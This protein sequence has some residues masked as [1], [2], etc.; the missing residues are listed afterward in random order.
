[1]RH[2]N[3]TLCGALGLV[4]HRNKTFYGALG[5]VRHINEP[6]CGA[7]SSMRHINFF[8]HPSTPPVDRLFSVQKITK[9]YENFKKNS[10][11]LYLH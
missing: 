4:R 11:E 3:K 1:V 9:K 10:F 7:W 5:L 6:F 8:N 2:R